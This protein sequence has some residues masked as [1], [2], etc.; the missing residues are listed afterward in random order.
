MDGTVSISVHRFEIKRKREGF[1]KKGFK[2][3]SSKIPIKVK[4]AKII[5]ESIISIETDP[6]D[7]SDF[8]KNKKQSPLIQ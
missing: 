7:F 8:V 6:L 3:I 5:C 4:K 2:I 1:S